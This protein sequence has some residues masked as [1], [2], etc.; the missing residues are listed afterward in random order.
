MSYDELFTVTT[1]DGGHFELRH[2]RPTTTRHSIPVFL[3]HGLAA[4]HRNLD[5]FPD[6]SLA[7]ALVREGREVWL[8]TLRSGLPK[9]QRSHAGFLAMARY[10]LPL[11]MN[12]ILRRSGAKQVDYVGFSMGGMLLYAGLAAQTLKQE[13]L[14][15]IVFI[16]CPARFEERSCLKQLSACPRWMIPSLPLR[17]LFRTFAF[18]AGL[19]V[20]PLHR[21]ICNPRNMKREEIAPAMVNII[22]DIP[23]EL[24]FDLL[25]HLR[26]GTL[27]IG[28]KPVLRYLSEVDRPALFLAGAKDQVAPPIS[29]FAAFES[30]GSKTKIFE[31]VKAEREFGHGD[32][33]VGE[34]AARVVFPRVVNF[35]SGFEP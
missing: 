18:L 17:F 27:M 24:S 16:A 23:A 28:D 7:R 15:R 22:E 9:S 5:A 32:L 30:W 2:L 20:T 13:E 6:S 29:V 25:N 11:A 21:F 33:V 26:N 35:L 8:I 3:V 14:R 34:N 1:P 19:I 12:E 31:E 4:N 10:D